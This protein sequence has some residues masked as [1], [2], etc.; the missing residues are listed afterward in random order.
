[1]NVVLLVLLLLLIR[2]IN[3]LR[4]V[5]FVS[6]CLFVSDHVTLGFGN[7]AELFIYLFI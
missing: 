4:K 3:Y 1:L 6:I 7:K 5:V 2:V